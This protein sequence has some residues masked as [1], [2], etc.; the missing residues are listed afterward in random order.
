MFYLDGGNIYIHRGDSATFDIVFG[1]VEGTDENE[2]SAKDVYGIDWVPEDGTTIRFSVKCDTGRPKPVI[3][4]D[5]VVWDGYVCVDL[6]PNDTDCLPPGEY[7]WDIRLSF[8][9]AD[10]L[11]WNTPFNPFNFF[12]CEVV[13]NAY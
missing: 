9:D 5:Y 1:D 7:V 6:M 4:K 12:V 2:I 8:P 10:F 11:D 13:S 3:Q